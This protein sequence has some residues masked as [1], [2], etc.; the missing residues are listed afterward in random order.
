M[1]ELMPRADPRVSEVKNVARAQRQWHPRNGA[2]LHSRTYEALEELLRE[3]RGTEENILVERMYVL[4]PP[5]ESTLDSCAWQG[6]PMRANPV[7]SLTTMADSTCA[8]TPFGF[9]KTLHGRP[10]ADEAKRGAGKLRSF[11]IIARER[12]GRPAVVLG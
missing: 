12:G 3:A 8:S 9:H 11:S 1:Q 6:S 10:V 7:G 5:T 4:P 2:N